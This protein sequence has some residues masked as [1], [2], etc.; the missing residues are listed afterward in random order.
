MKKSNKTTGGLNLLFNPYKDKEK[1][2]SKKAMASE[3][4]GFMPK[5]V[6][7]L[8]KD[9]KLVSYIQ[10]NIGGGSFNNKGKGHKKGQ[11]ELSLLNP[12]VVYQILKYYTEEGD[13]VLAPYSSRGV[14]GFMCNLMGRHSVN[15]EIVPTYLEDMHHRAEGVI[16]SNDNGCLLEFFLDDARYLKTIPDDFADLTYFN[17]PY[18][19]VERYESVDGQM[20]DHRNYDEFLDDY[21]MAIQQKFRTTKPGGWCI[22]NLNDFRQV[23][24]QGG[25]SEFIDFHVDTINLMKKAGFRMHDMII[26]EIFSRSLA[27]IGSVEER[28][29]KI[30]AKSHE[31]LMI[32]K[33]PF[34]DGTV[35]KSHHDYI[36]NQRL[37]FDPKEVLREYHEENDIEPT[38]GYL[39]I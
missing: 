28:G 14:V 5:S 19:N 37:D 12:N 15:T 21:Y 36:E 29:L 30:M 27:S 16:K 24:N 4:Y 18:Y 31:Y 10:D 20:S 1:D 2:D 39:T 38:Y 17:P 11:T 9:K 25:D 6:W 22:A 34:E 7:S 13:I 8:T 33:K 35:W 26:N 3:K 32:F 23:K